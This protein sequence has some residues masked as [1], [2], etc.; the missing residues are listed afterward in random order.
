[1][2][3]HVHWVCMVFSRICRDIG[4]NICLRFVFRGIWKRAF[5]WNFVGSRFLGPL[6]NR[7]SRR[8]G[9]HLLDDYLATGFKFM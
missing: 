7:V 1:M 4:E 9:L 3:M 8:S 5:M 2:H 6:G